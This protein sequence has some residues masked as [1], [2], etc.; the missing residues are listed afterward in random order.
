MGGHK[1][2]RRGRLG[3]DPDAVGSAGGHT[4]VLTAAAS[5]KIGDVVYVSAQ[6]TVAKS[7]TGTNYAAFAGVV[8]GGGSQT[9]HDNGFFDEASVGLAIPTGVSNVIQVNGIANVVADSAIAAGA[10]VIPSATTAGRVISG[11]TAGQVLGI[12]L[13]AAVSAGDIVPML[14]DHR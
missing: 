9:G 10:T 4:I 7:V 6:R 5:H 3:Y 14:I 1:E 2:T 13:K 11:T 8:I 12:A